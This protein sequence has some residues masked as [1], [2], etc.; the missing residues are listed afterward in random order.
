V[1]ARRAVLREGVNRLAR[2]SSIEWATSTVAGQGGAEVIAVRSELWAKPHSR[3]AGREEAPAPDLPARLQAGDRAAPAELAAGWGPRLYRYLLR[4]TRDPET[5][6]DLAQET[7]VRALRAML[8]GT[9][10][11][12]L[13]PWLYRIATNL[14][15]D[16]Y[17]SAYRRRVTLCD[18][19]DPPEGQP[20]GH[21]AE[22]LVLQAMAATE[23]QEAVRRAVQALPPDLHEVIVLRFAEGQP[24]KTIAAI[25]GIPEGT[26]K[27]RLYRAYRTLERALEPWRPGGEEGHTRG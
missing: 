13:A 15:R 5:A 4:F 25:L 10:P 3:R 22:R 6:R 24:V 27:S 16:D 7:L 14:A 11:D 9:R 23:R 17:R 12:D 8:G 26:V 18:A 21:S 20:A 19:L 1:G 2:R